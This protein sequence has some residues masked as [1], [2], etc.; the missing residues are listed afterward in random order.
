ME[1]RTIRR[2]LAKTGWVMNEGETD[3]RTDGA[4]H[5][6]AAPATAS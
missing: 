1:Y 3:R 2:I 4:S 5:G 6:T